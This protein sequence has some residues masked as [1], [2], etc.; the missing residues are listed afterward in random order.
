[1]SSYLLSRQWGARL[2]HK[3][4]SASKQNNSIDLEMHYS[5]YRGISKNTQYRVDLSK[6]VNGRA[7]T[8]EELEPRYRFNDQ[9]TSALE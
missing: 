6:I 1:M 5:N 7:F 9:S 2:S 8:K 3:L 4:L